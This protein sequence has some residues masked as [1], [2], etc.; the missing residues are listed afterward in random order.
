MKVL[1]QLFL[2]GFV[3]VFNSACGADSHAGQSS[4]HDTPDSLYEE[5][6]LFFGALDQAL[7]RHN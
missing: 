6:A 7:D 1:Q 4:R 3:G 5:Q 2:L